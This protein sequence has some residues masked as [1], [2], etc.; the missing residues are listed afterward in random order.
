M[1]HITIV[2][3]EA[4]FFVLRNSNDCMGDYTLGDEEAMKAYI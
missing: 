1:Y 4:T 3:D 2:K